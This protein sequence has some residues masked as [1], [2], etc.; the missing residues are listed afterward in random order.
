MIE[1]GPV[2][3][4]EVMR[5]PQSIDQAKSPNFQMGFLYQHEFRFHGVCAWVG[6]LGEGA[7]HYNLWDLGPLI[8]P[9]ERIVCVGSCGDRRV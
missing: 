7:L 9:R 3:N 8:K 6:G 4:P 2:D 5:H 1:S